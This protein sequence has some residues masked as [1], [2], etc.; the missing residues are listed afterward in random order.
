MKKWRN[1]TAVLGF[2]SS[3][4]GC[5]ENHQGILKPSP[6]FSVHSFLYIVLEEGVKNSERTMKPLNTTIISVLFLVSMSKN[7]GV[8]S[9]N[10]V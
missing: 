4:S 5:I 8:H 10:H 7:V 1:T 3:D 9:T 6:F 2:S